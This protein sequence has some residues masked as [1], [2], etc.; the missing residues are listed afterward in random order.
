[1]DRILTGFQQDW[2]N[3]S[4]SFSTGDLQFYLLIGSGVL[5]I[6]LLV[7]ALTRWGQSRP[8]WKCV[9]LS[10]VAH[11]LLIGWA[12]GT[13]LMFETP[14]VAKETD[15]L[16]VNLIEELGK[17][18]EGDEADDYSP[19][20][21]NEFV[22]EQ[23]LPEVE[24]LDRA[25]VDSEVVIQR[26]SDQFVPLPLAKQANELP[27]LEETIDVQ[28]LAEPDLETGNLQEITVED[29]KIEAQEIEFA[30]RGEDEDFQPQSPQF[31]SPSEFARPEIISDAAQEPEQEVS[32][33]QDKA[34]AAAFVSELLARDAQLP[35]SKNSMPSPAVP[36]PDAG[37]KQIK[38][39]RAPNRMRLISSKR[40]LGDGQPLP[41]VYSLRNAENR[42]EVARRRGGSIET[43]QA[44]NLALRW[45]AVNQQADGRW[46]AGDSGAGKETRVFGHDRK[47]AG[48]DADCGITGLATLSFLAAGHT[49]LEGPYQDELKRAIEYLVR[50]QKLDGN[51][52]GDARLFARMYCHSMSLLAISEA[53]AL[54]GD[55]RLLP[56]VQRG[57]DYSVRAQNRRDG[58]WRYQPGDSGDMS[59]FGWQVLAL[60]SAKLGG[61]VV[62]A[63]TFDRMQEFLEQCCSGAG[64]GLASYRPGQ[65]PS[66]TMTAE[67]L[68]CRYF[69][70]PSVPSMTI[71]EAARQI[72]QER[73]SP[74]HVN[75]YYW[76][77]GT[78]AMYHV[79]GSDWEKWNQ[80]MK[81][82]L[83][84]LQEKEGTN[85]GSWPANGVWGGYGGRVYAT[86]MATLNLEVYYRY[87]PLYDLATET[88]H[89]P[90]FR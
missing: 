55:Q 24:R 77:Y 65:G 32:N 20:P 71:M 43:E 8:V 17:S 48:A 59:Q 30:R 49:H 38:P 79:G 47:G 89:Q 62:P 67:A 80:A 21:W 45:L 61:A 11:I 52:A 50:Q 31:E 15:T 36:R 88:E 83:L 42:L 39:L 84:Q 87:L 66:T 10:I 86:A 28:P 9:I 18:L 53:L 57:V 44:V 13:H 60:H 78:L 7:L 58:G 51:L 5:A 81:K 40:R 74:Q 34:P 27:E 12:Y 33:E 46:D 69:L 25:L 16:R 85:E 23:F 37:M 26:N 41:K 68:L 2:Q 90:K 29:S 75:L 63:A 76:Y 6:S 72:E 19:Q 22:N 4:Q 82:T 35:L 70:Q 3:V 64:G 1:M 73:P 54:T 56:F 14:Q